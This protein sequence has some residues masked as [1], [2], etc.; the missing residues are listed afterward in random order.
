MSLMFALPFTGSVK[1]QWVIYD[2]ACHWWKIG[3]G[4]PYSVVWEIWYAHCCMRYGE[5]FSPRRGDYD[6]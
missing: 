2:G 5:P 1:R 6:V 4:R 3:R